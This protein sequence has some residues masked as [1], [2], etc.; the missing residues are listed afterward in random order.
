MP[1][2]NCRRGVT[3]TE[4]ALG[5]EGLICPDCQLA[6]DPRQG[7]W[8]ARHPDAAWG[9]G[10]W[11]CHPMVPCFY[12]HDILQK[13]RTYDS[14]KFKNECLGLSTTLG[15]HV[16]TREEVEA[17]C[18][19]RP[20]AL[21]GEDIL[22]QWRGRLLAGIDWGGGAA[23]RTALTIGYMRPD[24]VFEVCHL[25]RFAANE[26]PDYL[27]NQ[28]AQRCRQF[29]VRFVAADGGGAGFHLNRLLANRLELPLYAII[30]TAGESPP[31]QNGALWD[32]SVHRTA[33]IGN[34]FARIKL[35]RISF[36]RMEDFGS[37]LNEFAC[38]VAEY[39]DHNRTIKY[40]HPETQPDDALHSTN[41]ALLMGV[42]SL[43][44]ASAQRHEI[45]ETYM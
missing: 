32:W 39:D 5:T 17:C 11:I 4:R 13:Q 21:S 14:V 23:A 35:G 42:R 28:V 6:V 34:L 25:A 20:M 24:N 2:Q 45:G 36:P 44:S 3:I 37:Y 40:T 19:Q 31:R 8:I 1:C 22:P 26:E 33:S 41:Y 9:S 27:L 10:Y 16:V 29:G 43:S 38:E 15:E 18:S 7:R 30:Y 12:Y